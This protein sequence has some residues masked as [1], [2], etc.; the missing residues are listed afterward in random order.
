MAA[1]SDVPPSVTQRHQHEQF[2]WF[3]DSVVRVLLD[4]TVTGGRLSVVENHAT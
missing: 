1:E 4:A 3:E 2:L